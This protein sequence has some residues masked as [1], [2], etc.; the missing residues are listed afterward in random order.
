MR[1]ALLRLLAVVLSVALA[2]LAAEG[3]LR[4]YFAGKGAEEGD[5]RAA[6]ARSARAPV[7]KEGGRFNLSGLVEAS[8]FPD[9]V[10][11]LKPNLSGRF[12]GRSV[13]TNAQGLRGARDYALAKPPGTLRIAGLGDSVMFGWGVGEGEPYLQVVEREL[14]RRG[15]R[16]EVLSFAVPGY[17]TSLEVA[18]F[19]RRALP[20]S[21]DLVVLHFIGND[22]GL[23]H[24]LRRPDAP[25]AGGIAPSRW[26]LAEVLRRRFRPSPPSPDDEVDPD[27]I[28]HDREVEPAVRDE[29]R[30]QYQDLLGEEAFARALARLRRLTAPRRIPVIVLALGGDKGRGRMARDLAEANGFTFLNAGPRFHEYLVENGLAADRKSWVTT[31]RVPKDGH[32]NALGHRLYAEALLGELER[33]KMV[34]RATGTTEPGW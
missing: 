13:R 31:F 27:L 29:A 23:P 5:V 3:A 17:N 15:R 10:Y 9:V 14:N 30:Q 28:G 2:L 19:E 26:R 22:L 6:L 12:R 8:P 4:L 20:Y 7:G 16:A 25:A 32:P 34:P 24:F 11:Q 18:A 21:P 33:R 1:R